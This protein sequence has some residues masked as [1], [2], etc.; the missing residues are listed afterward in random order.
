METNQHTA[1][2]SE[3]LCYYESY[4]FAVLRIKLAYGLS[5]FYVEALSIEL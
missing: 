5:K 4:L 2:C 1:M 3:S